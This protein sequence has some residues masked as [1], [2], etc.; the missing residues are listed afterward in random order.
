MWALDWV[1]GG[2]EDKYGQSTLYTCMKFLINENIIFNK[3]LIVGDEQIYF[4]D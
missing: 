1:G 3:K 4:Y 2:V